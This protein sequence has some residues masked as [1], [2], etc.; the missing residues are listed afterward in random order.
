MFFETWQNI[1]SVLVACPK[2]LFRPA[3]SNMLSGVLIPSL[4]HMGHFGRTGQSEKPDGEW[5]GRR[6]ID[7]RTTSKRCLP[8]DGII[9]GV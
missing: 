9:I 5:W 8:R 3:R 2:A 7:T 1:F 6:V 4:L